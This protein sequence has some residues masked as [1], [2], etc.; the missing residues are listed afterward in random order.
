[1]SPSSSNPT[2]LI[3]SRFAHCQVLQPNFRC[4]LPNLLLKA[5]SKRQ[6]REVDRKKKREE[7]G[8]RSCRSTGRGRP[9]W[10]WRARE[11]QFPTNLFKR[12]SSRGH[13]LINTAGS[14]GLITAQWARRRQISS[15]LSC[16]G[17]LFGDTV[18][19]SSEL[20]RFFEFRFYKWKID[21]SSGIEQLLLAAA[22]SLVV[23]RSRS[24]N[25]T[26]TEAMNEKEKR[27]R[28]KIRDF[29]IYLA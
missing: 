3:L 20:S 9:S 2:D 14:L 1:M 23:L 27:L 25:W 24:R 29:S 16:Y 26:L 11:G 28:K 22:F 21:N 4:P 17:P 7:S 6:G 18:D 10:A 15:F 5:A 19:C 12:Q 13:H 8:E